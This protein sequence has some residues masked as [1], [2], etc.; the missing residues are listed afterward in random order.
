MRLLIQVPIIHSQQ[1]LGSLSE[2]VKH[3]YVRQ[4][5][6]AKW[7]QHQQAIASF[8]SGIQQSIRELIG[9]LSLPYAKVRLYQDGLPDAGPVIEIVREVARQGSMN[10][11][12]LL[13]LA[14]SGA[15][16]MGTESPSLLIEEYKSYRAADSLGSVP[17]TAQHASNSGRA[18][19]LLAERD[20]YIAGR[21]NSTL[22]ADEVGIL[23]LGAAHSVKKF[24]DPDIEL[25]NL[26]PSLS[27]ATL[28]SSDRP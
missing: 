16:L 20:R 7:E 26:L 9:A 10:H 3:E 5:G 15:T 19:Q 27:E 11:Q 13:E 28:P 18:H 4:H 1:D 14:E 24:L 21:I 17:M 23:F 8:W 6:L 2:R 22:L 12:L 25:K